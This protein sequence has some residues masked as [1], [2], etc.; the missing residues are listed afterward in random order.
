MLILAFDTTNARGG[1]GIFRDLD[2]LASVDH[3]GPANYSRTLFQMVDRALAE[4]KLSLR[5]IE[6]FAA[7]NG[8]GSFTG[9][10]V[11]V[12]AAQGWATA[13]GR[14]VKGVS[15]LEALVEEARPQTDQVA[16]ILDARRNEFFLGVFRRAANGQRVGFELQG[17]ALVLGVEAL[18]SHLERTVESG[19]SLSCLVRESDQVARGLQGT[20]T[21]RWR[22]VPGTLV[23]AIARLALE[24]HRQGRLQSPAQLDA[25]YIRRS[26]AELNWEKRGR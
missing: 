19:S 15:V 21:Y 3:E 22:I 24:A 4:A 10:R 13:L 14:P 18:R 8:P 2:C 5:E 1:V 11:G 12:A 20:L 9:I 6:L 7:A 25:C 17:E 16:A 26:D 23:P